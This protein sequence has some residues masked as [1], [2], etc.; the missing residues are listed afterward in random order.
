MTDGSAS[1]LGAPLNWPAST[2][3]YAGTAVYLA[4]RAAFTRLTVRQVPPAQLVAA[5]ALLILLPVSR[6]LSALAALAVVS[7]TLIAL[8]AFEGRTAAHEPDG[9]HENADTPDPR[10]D[11]DSV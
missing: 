6:H 1:N 11:A 10:T 9:N 5:A 3:L 2:A 8:T 4:G 7:V